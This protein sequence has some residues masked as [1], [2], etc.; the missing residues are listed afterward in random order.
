L[1][2]IIRTIPLIFL[3][4]LLFCGAWFAL[5]AAPPPVPE[6]PRLAVLLVFDQM[7]ADYLTRWQEL[8]VEGGFRR[9]QREGAWFQDCNY[10]Y[11][12][13]VTAAGHASLLTGCCP[14]R[15]GIVGNE[16]F[17]PAAGTEVY[18]VA[19][20]RYHRVPALSSAKTGRPSGKGISPENLLCPTVGDVLKDATGGKARVI[21]LSFKD[22][23]AVLTGGHRA[24]ACFWFDN[25]SAQV[26][27]SSC[28]CEELPP[29]VE[30]FNR[31]RI[32]DRWQDRDWTR[33]RPDLDYVRHSGPDDVAAEGTG[34]RQGRTF[35]HPF[36][37]RSGKGSQY[38]Q[39]VYNSPAGNNLLLELTK[40]AID[41]EHLGSHDTPDLLCVSFSSND[42]VGH[43]YGPDSQEV[44]DITLRSD[45][46]V[47]DL[48]NYLDSKVG[49]G[50]YV[51]ALTADHGVC[52]LPEVA[53]AQ[54]KD[55]MRILPAL[56]PSQAETFLKAKF[57]KTSDSSK[58]LR[59]FSPPW[60][61]LNHQA[62]ERQGL[63]SA[64]VEIA[65][66]EWLLS[67]RGILAAYTRTQLLKGLPEND[68]LGQEVRR[69]FYPSRCGDVTAVLKPYC[70]L[71]LGFTGT[72]HGTP[73]S[74]DTHVPLL[75][76][77]PGIRGGI[78]SEKVT[79]QAIAAI[80]SRIL[81]IPPP[82]QAEYPVPKSL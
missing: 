6:K 72:T 49:T 73:H 77:G 78:R 10:A 12:N 18:C 27:T 16:W 9:L 57:G 7:R 24:D 45:L 41:A 64:D 62:L 76:F 79:P 15:H 58:W 31:S 69:S 30:E 53:R 11:A 23:S 81:Q 60:I 67:Q 59:A 36:G 20:D 4:E 42:A 51:V 22:R 34:A 65:L 8:F 25:D 37:N 63:K 32:V 66:A 40:R 1:Q 61:Y 19:S 26:I 52:P 48:L 70:L 43:C 82:A 44:L 2:R 29:W 13:T 3:F 35:P 33:L 68:K 39:A 54:G 17:D 74:Y 75:V 50:R 5:Q 21:A 80:F 28:Y 47:H 56:W 55:A 38:Y 71:S 46:I 14:D